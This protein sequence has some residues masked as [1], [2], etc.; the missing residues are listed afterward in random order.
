MDKMVKFRNI[1][2]HQYQNVDAEIVI[3][4]LQKH[5]EDFGAFKEA[6]LK[7]IKSGS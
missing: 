6:I 1:V 4:I 3:T 7:Q 5:L 2:F